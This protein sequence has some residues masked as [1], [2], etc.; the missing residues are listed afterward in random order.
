MEGKIQVWL[1]G[2]ELGYGTPYDF[3]PQY[4]ALRS[5]GGNAQF[6]SINWRATG[7]DGRLARLSGTVLIPGRPFL[8]EEKFSSSAKELVGGLMGGLMSKITGKKEDSNTDNWPKN[9]RDAESA[10]TRDT[11][12]KRLTLTGLKDGDYGTW[13][14]PNSLS[15]LDEATVAITAR[16][17]FLA[18]LVPNASG[19]LYLEDSWRRGKSDDQQGNL[20][21]V[22]MLEGKLRFEQFNAKTGTWTLLHGYLW[23]YKDKNKEVELRLVVRGGSAWV[24]VDRHLVMSQSLEGMNLGAI[25]GGGMR[26]G[27]LGII[28]ANSFR[29]DEL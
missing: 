15:P 3:E 7:V 1:D 23:P 25:S 19:G 16:V 9:W 12:T 10:F 18:A 5:E 8:M 6:S 2:Q 28:E 13:V 29:I 17:K 4:I 14:S 22:N 24:F 27:G 26:V 21:Y 20:L 11:S